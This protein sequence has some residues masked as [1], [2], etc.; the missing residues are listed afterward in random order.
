MIILLEVI[1]I[2]MSWQSF[3]CK[4]LFHIGKLCQISIILYAKLNSHSFSTLILI[5]TNTKKGQSENSTLPYK[6]CQLR[7]HVMLV[8]CPSLSALPPMIKIAMQAEPMIPHT[9]A[10]RVPKSIDESR[11]SPYITSPSNPNHRMA[12]CNSKW[13]LILGRPIHCANRY[14]QESA[15]D[16][17]FRFC[18]DFSK[19]SDINS[20][21]PFRICCYRIT[22]WFVV[23][24][25]T[26]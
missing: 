25:I 23:W 11:Q 17:L 20:N 16:G 18:Q 1:W 22:I 14:M 13:H 15:S 4:N 7:V 12:L 24:N 2:E 26:L 19:A 3:L 10:E 9:T 8:P 21:S 5:K 6:R